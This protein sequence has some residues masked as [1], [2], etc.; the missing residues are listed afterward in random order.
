MLIETI[1]DQKGR[2]C[3]TIRPDAPV[4][5]AVAILSSRRVGAVVVEDLKGA[6]VGIFSERDLVRL[7]AKR[8][9]DALDLKLREAMTSPVITCKPSDRIDQALAIMNNRK[10][11]HLPVVSNGSL[12]GMISIR[13]IARVQLSE[14]ENEAAVLLDIAR[15][16]G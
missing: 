2:D 6:I 16:H 11:R 14:K 1:L 8:G 3:A 10:V 7:L 9:R 5:A 15:L 4:S 13:D 12:A